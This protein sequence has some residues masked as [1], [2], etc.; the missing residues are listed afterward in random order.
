MYRVSFTVCRSLKVDKTLDQVAL[1]FE[2]YPQMRKIIK[3][4]L[5]DREDI[6]AG[7]AMVVKFEKKE[8]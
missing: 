5:K 6:E 1:L 4:E 2:V 7:L 3:K 8:E